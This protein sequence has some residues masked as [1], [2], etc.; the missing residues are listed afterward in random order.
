MADF[1]SD[2]AAKS[3]ISPEQAQ[4]GLGAVLSFLKGSLPE[5]AFAKVSAAVPDSDQMMAAAGPRE[6]AVGG[7]LGAVKGMAGKLLGG[8]ALAARLSSLGV[9]PEQVQGFLP[10]VLE[11]LKGRVP[12][13]VLKQ[14]SDVFQAPQEKGT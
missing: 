13:S 7:I 12:D 5:D 4:K 2:L 9:S 8:G 11:F 14:I 3:G 1:I 10:R 6:E